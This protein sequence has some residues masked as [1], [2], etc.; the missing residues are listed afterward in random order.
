MGFDASLYSSSGIEYR[1]RQAPER[2]S[3]TFVQN[4]NQ[5]TDLIVCKWNDAGDLKA[6]LMQSATHV[7]G[8]KWLTRTLPL[9][10]PDT[11]Y[12]FLTAM[13]SVRPLMSNVRDGK[14]EG[15]PQ[16]DPVTKH[17]F[18]ERI[19]YQLTFTNL[20]YKVAT[21]DDVK[22]HTVPELNRHVTITPQP[23]A[24]NRVVSSQSLH[25]E[26][27]AT[28]TPIN[29]PA[30]I[31]EIVT[32][33]LVKLYMWPKEA[34]NWGAIYNRM[35]KVNTETFRLYGIDH[36]AET[37][38]YEGI[39]APAEEYHGPDGSKYVDITHVLT[40]HPVNWNKTYFDGEWRYMR[41]GTADPPRRRYLKETMN[42]IF[43]PR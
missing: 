1:Y 13:Q 28:F 33:F 40:R 21:D 4:G 2:Y 30:A 35:G 5:I 23:I 18:Y 41:I 12:L 20:P 26:T 19:E 43:W 16:F 17:W 42:E 14:P 25:V 34:V 29:Q 24:S 8:Q 32:R 6:D 7:T 36:P 27:G 22:A 10:Y 37:L 39:G 31:P 38:L 11:D 9:K 15:Y 3:E